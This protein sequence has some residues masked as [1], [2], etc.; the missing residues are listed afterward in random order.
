VLTEVMQLFP[1]N[2][3]HIGGDECPK[4]AWKQ[5]EFCQQLMKKNNLKD[6]HELQSYFIQRVE[7]FVNSKGKKII[8]WDEI[9]EGGLAPN[10]AV[11]SW[12]GEEGGKDAAKQKHPVVMT[13][14]G[15]CYFDHSQF[16]NEDSLTIGGYTTTEK[17]YSYQPFPSSGLDKEFAP[18]ILGAQAN[19]WTEYITNEKKLQYMVFPRIT[20]LA[21]V[22]W[23][24]SE[25]K[26][27]DDFKKRAATVLQLWQQRGVNIAR[28]EE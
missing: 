9:L 19:L 10:A 14:G 28:L 25:N 3:I 16:K 4:T 23:S 2:Y 13:P 24:R 22:L 6:E 15:W 1:S 17:V 7:K 20:A 21:E 12:R 26:N 8:G 11:M 5:S 18:Y 27:W